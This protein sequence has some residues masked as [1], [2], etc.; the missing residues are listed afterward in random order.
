LGAAIHI[1]HYFAPCLLQDLNGRLWWVVVSGQSWVSCAYRAADG[2]PVYYDGYQQVQYDNSPSCD[3][4]PTMIN[5]MADASGRLWGWKEGQ[6]GE[7]VN[8]RFLKADGSPVMREEV[9]IA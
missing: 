3:A 2:S 7:G 6:E 4:T 5:A 8:C 1:S 9:F